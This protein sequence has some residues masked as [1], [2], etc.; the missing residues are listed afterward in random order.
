M[1]VRARSFLDD[2]LMASPGAP[3]RIVLAVAHSTLARVLLCVAMDVPV[4]EYRRRFTQGQ[5][6][7]TVL[8]Y[9]PDS[10]PS[11]ARLLVLNDLG[12]AASPGQAPWELR[13]GA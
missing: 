6:N 9:Q 11:Q 3:E 4:A 2:E 8:R 1:A 10:T 12:H 5:T 13:P 7:L